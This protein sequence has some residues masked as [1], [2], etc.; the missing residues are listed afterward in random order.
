MWPRNPSSSVFTRLGYINPQAL[1][2]FVHLPQTW[3]SSKELNVSVTV[4][5][6]VHHPSLLTFEQV[7]LFSVL[8][9]RNNKAM[10]K[11]E[12]WTAADSSF[13]VHWDFSLRGKRRRSFLSDCLSYVSCFQIPFG[14]TIDL[15]QYGNNGCT[16]C[17]MSSY[18]RS[19]LI[20]I[21]CY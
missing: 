9:S 21:N 11:I 3:K 15:I 4:G 6:V 7:D 19:Q 20:Q 10:G 5:F 13:G 16:Q 14:D 8:G 1:S 2:F 12:I 17:N 18:G